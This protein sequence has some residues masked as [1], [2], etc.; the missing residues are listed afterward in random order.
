LAGYAQRL[1]QNDRFVFKKMGQLNMFRAVRSGL[2]RDFSI[3]MFLY[4]YFLGSI[5]LSGQSKNF[6]VL[7][8]FELKTVSPGRRQFG[9]INL[10]GKSMFLVQ[11]Y[12][13]VPSQGFRLSAPQTG[14]C[15][16][17]KAGWASRN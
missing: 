14:R 7:C 10:Y 15:R 9:T 16:R 8:R 13:V 5:K 1:I 17:R 6:V 4:L 11:N 12:F 3:G 2:E